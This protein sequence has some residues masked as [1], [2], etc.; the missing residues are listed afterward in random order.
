MSEKLWP[1]LRLLVW[2]ESGALYYV[3]TSRGGKG[4]GG[5]YIAWIWKYWG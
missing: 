1:T 3:V 4:W 2:A 5:T